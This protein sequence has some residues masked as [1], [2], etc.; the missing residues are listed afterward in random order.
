MAA[1]GVDNAVD[2]EVLIIGLDFG[3]TY[4]MINCVLPY[5]I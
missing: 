4:A 3:T 1:N 2:N 5:G